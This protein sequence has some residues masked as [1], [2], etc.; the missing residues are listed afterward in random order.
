MERTRRTIKRPSW[1]EDQNG[2]SWVGPC[3]RPTFHFMRLTLAA[4]PCSALAVYFDLPLPLA[5]LP[6]PEPQPQARRYVFR[7]LKRKDVHRGLLHREVSQSLTQETAVRVSR[8]TQQLVR[9]S[10]LLNNPHT[11]PR[12]AR[13]KAAAGPAL[14][15]TTHSL[16]RTRVKVTSSA[17][18]SRQR[19]SDGCGP[20]TFPLP[21]PLAAHTDLLVLA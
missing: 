20:P 4:R 7:L 14:P 1:F 21:R 6:E 11:T 13:R 5:P 8:E 16:A 12:S 9:R 15:L 2:E 10:S 18:A 3:A 19:P 17:L